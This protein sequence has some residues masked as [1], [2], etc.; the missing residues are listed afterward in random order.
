MGIAFLKWAPGT[1]SSRDR[2]TALLLSLYICVSTSYPSC[3][4]HAVRNTVIRIPI[5]NRR[6]QSHVRYWNYNIQIRS[7][8]IVYNLFSLVSGTGFTSS[9]DTAVC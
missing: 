8:F 1:D 5:L 4:F 2:N 3:T 6:S 9:E 7:R